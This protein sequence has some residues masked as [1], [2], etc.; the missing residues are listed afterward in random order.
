MITLNQTALDDRY[1]IT[2]IRINLDADG[3][4]YLSDTVDK[5]TL[6][7]IDFDGKVILQDSISSITKDIDVINGGSIGQVGNFSLGIARYNN[8][9]GAS[10]FHEDFYPAT[11][12]PLLTSKEVSVGIIWQGATS[13]SD[14]TWL[15]YQYAEDYNYNDSQ[16]FLGCIASDELSATQIPYYTVQNEFDNDISYYTDQIN[17]EIYDIT[18]PIIYGDLLT[19]NVLTEQNK[20]VPIIKT[21]SDNDYKICSHICHTVTEGLY[22]SL[23]GAN[24]IMSLGADTVTLA[25]DRTGVGITLV[26]NAYSGMIG[27]IVCYP[28]TLVNSDAVNTTDAFDSDA[29]TYATVGDG[30]SFQFRMGLGINEQNYGSNDAN[31]GDILLKVVWKATTTGAVLTV[32]GINTTI[33]DSYTSTDTNTTTTSIQIGAAVTMEDLDQTLWVIGAADYDIYVYQVYIQ[34]PNQKVYNNYTE[35]SL[36]YKGKTLQTVRN[37][38]GSVPFKSL[39]DKAKDLGY[40]LLIKEINYL[41]ASESG[42]TFAAVKGYVYDSWVD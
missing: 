21:S 4:L 37:G 41:A 18:I 3:Y 5:I 32:A 19:T 9:S 40:E 35:T 22:R 25:N 13:L 38:I 36:R 17:N 29:S 1:L 7:G 6:D 11:G 31:A 14:I 34:M 20:L 26:T 39:N 12:K 27:D 33:N 24:A 2:I 8:Y 10:N 23:S 28:K 42:E 16:M 15:E 30:E